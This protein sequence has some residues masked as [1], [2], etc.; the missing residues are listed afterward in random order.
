M[1]TESIRAKRQSFVMKLTLLMLLACYTL[2]H[3]HS[4]NM[5]TSWWGLALIATWVMTGIALIVNFMAANQKI[6]L[7]TVI[8]LAPHLLFFGSEL[9]G[10]ARTALKAIFWLAFL[11]T[12][13]V[14]ISNFPKQSNAETEAPETS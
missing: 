13:G 8:L 1:H 10:S 9:D 3:A 2:K 6:P 14:E 12:L 4:F 11:F 5:S 7:F